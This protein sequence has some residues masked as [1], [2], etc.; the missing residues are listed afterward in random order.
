MAPPPPAADAARDPVCGMSVDPARAAA[1]HEHAGTTYYFC[2]TGCAARF[3]GD[4]ERYLHPDA[5]PEMGAMHAPPAAK[6]AS[7]SR[8]AIWTCPMDPEVRQDHPG[9]CPKCG[10]ALEPLEIAHD[11]GPS[12]E[13]VDMRR[14]FVV[15][16][17]LS[18]PLVVLSMGAM[19]AHALGG[20]VVSF[21]EL[22]LATP[23]VLGA[24]WPLLTRFAA[25]LRNRSPNMFTLIGLGVIAAFAFSVVATLAPGLFPASPHGGVDVYFE[26]A[27]VVVALVL[28]GQWLELGARAKTGAAVRALLDLAPKTARRVRPGADDEEIPLE[29]ARVGDL[30]R[31]RPGERVPVDGV[32]VEGRATLDE[33]MLT[34][35][36]L[37]VERGPNERVAGATVN[38]ASSF[39]L[40]ADRVGA[41]TLLARIVR[42]VQE[43]QRTRAPIQ[44]LADRVAA[45]FVPAVVAAAA[46]AFVAWAAFG[47]EPRFANALLSAVAVL[48]I[49]CP[50]AL[51]LAT[52]MSILVA[53][54]RAAREG[55]LFRDAEAIERIE[56][57][58]T[59]VVDKTGTLTEGR[60]RVV[61]VE[62]VAGTSEDDLLAVAASL[63]L[64]SEHPLS[65]AI[66]AEAR[67]RGA[68]FAAATDFRSIP[69]RGVAGRV[70][71]RDA[72][73]GSAAF[74]GERG[75]DASALATDERRA[76]GETL[77]FV[78][79]SGTLAGAI[80]VADRV[81]DTT[82]EALRALRADGV[83]V[84]ML[85]GDAR[86]TAEAIGHALGIESDDV[87][88][89]RTPEDKAAEVKRLRAVGRVVGM[90]GDGVNDA[91]A[92]ATADV[93]FA[94]GT[95]TDVAIES[96][97]VTLVRGDLGA[98]ARARALGRATM[99]NIRQNLF[100]AFVYNAVGIPLAAGVSFPWLGVRLGPMFAAA[101][102]AA[103]SI[104]V[105]GN[106]LRLARR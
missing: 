6:P 58:D 23:V 39:V 43:A 88:A 35:E 102:M 76:R 60:P 15:A 91:P 54:G 29:A 90:A 16:A 104:S 1:T 85:T 105:I 22:A 37:P 36:P 64:A 34:G 95:G 80:A 49:A 46:V 81:R 57:I 93:G 68:A 38:G 21:V 63:A 26:A 61:G 89:E 79:V 11:A 83:R 12:P 97:A 106:A 28:L 94:M 32:I 101:A 7:P 19:F 78:A 27:A 2:S 71:A 100:F 52:P 99:R 62:P 4:P 98:V 42:Q 41:D 24:G 70:G 40:R 48:V 55:V 74:L 51:G 14:R 8:A 84:V 9:A 10:M 18:A 73:L 25:S 53:T 72:A 77:V 75:V 59:L 13:L 82:A 31:V 3:R 44:R 96:A 103:S 87:L 30:L 50:C 45:V 33:S 69:G 67:A 65:A 20:R 17:A 5:V 56:R 47:P 66:V 86:A 92:L